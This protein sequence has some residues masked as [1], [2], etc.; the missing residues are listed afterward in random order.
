M[1]FLISLFEWMIGSFR[2]FVK[3]DTTMC[4][5]RFVFAIALLMTTV[6]MSAQQPYQIGEV[7][8]INM[9]DGRILFR[10]AKTDKPIEGKHR[11]IDGYHSAYIDA[12]F[13]EGLYNGDYEAFLDNRPIE[14]GHY[15]EGRKDGQFS[16]YSK[17][18][19]KLKE[20]KSYKNGKL[21][22]VS[23]SF[24]TDGKL[25]H[26]RNFKAGKQD[27]K[28]LRYDY[29]G[30]LRMDHNYK[31]GKQVGKQ[32][33]YMKGTYETYDTMYYNENG[34]PE[35]EYVSMFTFGKPR[36]VGYYKNGQK[37]GRWTEIAESG[38]TLD[39]S[40]YV[41]GKKDGFQ[42]VFDSE[43][44]KR[45]LEFSTHNDLKE[46]IYRKYDPKNG[47][48]IYEATYLH[49]RLNGKERTLVVDNRFDYWEISTYDNGR[50]TGPFESRYVK[51]NRIRETGH[52]E[53][54]HR[55]GRWKRFDI[56]GKLELE[57]EE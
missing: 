50:Q 25:E 43:T 19:G 45:K 16:Y 39:I 7:S 46:G 8:T 10:E 37:D 1:V 20:E 51:N 44:G 56:D 52:Y 15:K 24:Y 18:D 28:E 35:G 6:R 9:G 38:D 29:D 26:E 22:G 30:T 36:F 23:K 49:N 3:A 2:K 53:N 21:D 55:K 4:L 57:W 13:K 33:T 27:G 42:V 41:N 32:Y 12:G 17:F 54:G 47:E 48:L 11:I 31:N 34:L 40:T 5:F 14:K